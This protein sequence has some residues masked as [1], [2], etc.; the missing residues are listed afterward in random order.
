MPSPTYQSMMASVSGVVSS[1]HEA[2]LPL[3]NHGFL[4]GDSVYE[5]MRTFAGQV[6]R[7]PDHLERLRAS[8]AGLQLQVPWTDADL[9]EELDRFRAHLPTGEHYLRMVVTRGAGPL[10]YLAFDQAP[11]LVILGGPLPAAKKEEIPN[12]R[13]ILSQRRRNHRLAL[14]P[15]LKTGNLLN[16]RMA[17]MEAAQRGVDDAV[18]L[19]LEGFLTEATTSNLFLVRSGV[20]HTP[21]LS[22][23]LLGGITRKVVLELA[24]TEG[25]ES[26][27]G[28]LTEQD[29]LGADEIFLTSTTRSLGPVCECEGKLLQAPGPITRRLMAA[30]EGAYGGL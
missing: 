18:M 4:Y 10:S 11:E 27:Q 9:T 25:I 15:A 20:L 22:E 16:P 13:I 17:A 23:G 30:F 26:R 8:A 29:L 5:T 19:N 2:R 21:A 12:A 24:Q 3:A 1:L 7:W 6:F 14:D 28:R